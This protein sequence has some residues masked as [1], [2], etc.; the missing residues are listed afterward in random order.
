M[1]LLT[2][3]RDLTRAQG[4]DARIEA[5]EKTSKMILVKNAEIKRQNEENARQNVENMKFIEMMRI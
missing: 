2:L 1:L 4:K 5:L 3:P